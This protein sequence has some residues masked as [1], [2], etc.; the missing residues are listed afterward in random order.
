MTGAPRCCTRSNSQV[1]V[2]CMMPARLG[3]TGTPSPW[4]QKHLSLG[5]GQDH[6]QVITVMT[7]LVEHLLCTKNH[8]S[9]PYISFY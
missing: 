5:L 9:F 8:S 6:Y 3:G 2:L 7:T 1:K 4:R